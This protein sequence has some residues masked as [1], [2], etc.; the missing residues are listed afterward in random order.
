MLDFLE[1]I[2]RVG[3]PLMLL[4]LLSA[5]IYLSIGTGFFQFLHFGDM[6]KETV[7][8]LFGEKGENKKK[9]GITPFQAVSTA[10]AGTL[11]TGN[12]VGVATA[13]VSGGPGAVFWMVVTAF[14]RNDY[15]I[16]G[17]FAV[18]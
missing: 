7:I 18:G 13:I 16:C 10:L 9:N 3:S 15:K 2:N 17:G 8:H 12:I 11:G 6:L 5:G 14:F 1:K 4:F